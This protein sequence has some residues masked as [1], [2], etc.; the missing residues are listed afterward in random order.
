VKQP[1]VNRECSSSNRRSLDSIEPY[2][3][4]GIGMLQVFGATNKS[5]RGNA[6]LTKFTLK[7]GTYTP[8]CVPTA[9]L[10]YHRIFAPWGIN[11]SLHQPCLS[12]KEE[13]YLKHWTRTRSTNL[14]VSMLM[15]REM[16]LNALDLMALRYLELWSC[17]SSIFVSRIKAD[18]DFWAR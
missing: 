16:L 15:R 5:P 9:V 13:K 14:L 17:S 6:S 7:E 3:T 10:L 11:T 2:I 1:A 18:L 12:R 8:S 4:H